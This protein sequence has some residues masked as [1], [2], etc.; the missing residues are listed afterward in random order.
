MLSKPQGYS[1]GHLLY[2]LA[3]GSMGYVKSSA[4][5]LHAIAASASTLFGQ[6]AFR[7]FHSSP[8][9]TLAPGSSLQTEVPRVTFPTALAIN[10]L[11]SLP[12][13]DKTFV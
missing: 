5:L 7:D 13:S 1:V 10:S 6:T 2:S 3:L 4:K 11:P 12:A 9:C 8:S